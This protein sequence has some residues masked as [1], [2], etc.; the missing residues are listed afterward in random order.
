MDAIG[1]PSCACRWRGSEMTAINRIQ[2]FLL[3]ESGATAIEYGLI[4]SLI[5]VAIIS[6]LTLLS[7]KIQNTFNEVS[8]NLK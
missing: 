7:G 8:S 2:R 6:A 4:T 3:E 5:A 1:A